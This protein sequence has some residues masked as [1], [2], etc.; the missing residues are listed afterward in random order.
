MTHQNESNQLNEA[1]QLRAE[2][3]FEGM[4]QAM[5][6]L[7]NEAMKLERQQYLGVGP[8][9]RGEQRQTHANGFKSK[10]VQMPPLPLRDVVVA[11]QG[12]S[13]LRALEAGPLGMLDDDPHPPPLDIELNR[14]H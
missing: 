9:Q 2:N 1:V 7:I 3:G 4:A 8:Y 10:V 14:S 6:L 12:A 5:Q 11:G 13:A